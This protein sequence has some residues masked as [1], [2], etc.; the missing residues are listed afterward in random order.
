MNKANEVN[1]T[2]ER[3]EVK[4]TTLNEAMKGRRVKNWEVRIHDGKRSVL[5]V[6]YQ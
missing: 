5:Y 1:N 6:R 4:P 3:C 2:E